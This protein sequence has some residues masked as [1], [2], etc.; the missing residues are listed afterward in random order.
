MVNQ[1]GATP[2][3]GELVVATIKTVKQNGAYVDLDEYEGI[4]GSS[5]L[6]KSLRDG[7]KTSVVSSAK[8]SESSARFCVP[9]ETERRLNS[10]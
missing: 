5:S 1:D 3:E 8:V 7:S 2:E 4:E 10:P 6:A 9:G